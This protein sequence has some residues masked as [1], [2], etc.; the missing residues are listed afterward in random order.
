M[1]YLVNEQ[2]TRD[3]FRHTLLNIPVHNLVNLP[4]QLVCYLCPAAFYQLTHHTHDI[5]SA[6]RSGIGHI[7]IVQ[8]HVLYQLLPLVHISFRQGHILFGFKVIF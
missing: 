1:A 3:K 7:Q 8:R 2:H 5:L 6:L 4:S